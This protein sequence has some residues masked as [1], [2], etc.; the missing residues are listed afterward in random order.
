MM[1]EPPQ[2]F[3]YV[4]RIASETPDGQSSEDTGL[5]ID[6]VFVYVFVGPESRRRFIIIKPSPSRVT[7]SVMRRD[8]C[9]PHYNEF[10]SE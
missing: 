9:E 4:D 10:R 6:K 2:A 1:C 3:K 5:L 7:H 8:G